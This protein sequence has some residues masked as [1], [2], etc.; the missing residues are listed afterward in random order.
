M[1]ANAS[2]TGRA[3]YLS[4]TAGTIQDTAPSSTNNVVRVV[5]YAIGRD[6]GYIYFNPSSTWIKHG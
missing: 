6:D 1:S 3:V 5:G 2:T 4:T